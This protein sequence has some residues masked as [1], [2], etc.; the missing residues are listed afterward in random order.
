MDND[1]AFLTKIVV[2]NDDQEYS[3]YVLLGD[4]QGEAP[5]RSATSLA[6]VIENWFE[7]RGIQFESQV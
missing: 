3:W 1:K 7:E 4:S 6:V 2:S 5:E